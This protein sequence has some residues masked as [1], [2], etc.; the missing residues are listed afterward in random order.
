VQEPLWSQLRIAFPQDA[1]EW[2]IVELSADLDQARVRPQLIATAVKARL[3]SVLGFEGWS[4]HFAPL[5]GKAVICEI[6]IRD[7]SKAAVASFKY[8]W[9]DA[10]STAYDAFVYAA[11]AFGIEPSLD[12]NTPYWVDYDPENQTILFEPELIV[13][14]SQEPPVLAPAKLDKPEGQQ[15]IDRL[16]DRLRHEGMGLDAAKLLVSYGGYGENPEAARELY[17]KLRALLVQGAQ[18]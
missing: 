5:E 7:I 10:V 2:R 18:A 12:K 1:L 16:V 15:A 14:L 8:S 13:P 3:D 9:Q 17:S 11:E 4:Q 6:K